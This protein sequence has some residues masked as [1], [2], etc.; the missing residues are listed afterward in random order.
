MQSHLLPFLG[1][2]TTLLKDNVT[3]LTSTDVHS[4]NITYLTLEAT[5]ELRFKPKN[6]DR[7]HVSCMFTPADS[8]RAEHLHFLGFQ[9][10]EF[11][12]PVRAAD[13]SLQFKLFSRE[14]FVRPHSILPMFIFDAEK[15]RVLLLAAVDAFHEQVLAARDGQLHWG[16]SGDLETVPVGFRTTL[17]V[18]VHASPRTALQQWGALVC[19]RANS[20]RSGRFDT[21][22]LSHLS[23]WTDNGAAYWYRRERNGTLPDGIVSAVQHIEAVADVNVGVV[24]LDSWFY[25]HAITREVRDFGYIHVVPPT[26]LLRWEPRADVLGEDGIHGLRKRLER[27]P[28]IL[29]CRHISAESPYAKDGQLGTWWRDGDR[30]HPASPALWRVWMQQAAA[31]GAIAVE[32]DWLVEVWQGVRALRAIPGRVGAWQTAFAAAAQSEGLS[33][34][35]CMATPADMASAAALPNVLVAR[36]CD[37]Y[38]YADD[39]STLWRWHVTISVVLY[40]LGMLPFKD[41]FMSHANGKG[42]PDVDGDPHAWFEA[43]LATL[44]AGPVGVGDRAGRTN[45]AVIKACARADGAIVKPDA[46]LQILDRSLRNAGGLLWADTRSGEWRYIIAACTGVKRND[47]PSFT[48]PLPEALALADEYVEGGEEIDRRDSSAG[49]VLVYDWRQ[50]AAKVADELRV[51]LR[52]H[53]WKLWVLCPLFRQEGGGDG[54]FTLIGDVKLFATMGDRRFRV[55]SDITRGRVS[56]EGLRFDVVGH[57]GEEVDVAYWSEAGGVQ[58]SSV[59]IPTRGWVRASLNVGDSDH[60]R[61]QLHVRNPT[62]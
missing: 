5:A 4:N 27:R 26:G 25:P 11:G 19:A 49:E 33:V 56:R 17:A 29:H 16:W 30:A 51:A 13:V 10:T 6:Y 15:P 44:S 35:W 18:I 48:Q 45:A 40:A 21:P 53:E 1:S 41:V 61:V 8:P 24:E 62:D 58:T 57:P 14:G 46:P 59:R 39:P 31:W 55:L 9:A 32:H 50:G 22:L 37:D 43:C 2:L 36:S 60:Q 42:V 34:V 38:R 28:L 20:R 7:P 3:L 47:D 52:I 23:Y 12:L 54:A